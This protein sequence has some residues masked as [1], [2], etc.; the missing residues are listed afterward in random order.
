MVILCR[1]ELVY[2]LHVVVQL[3]FALFVVLDIHGALRGFCGMDQARTG[4][5]R[6]KNVSNL[7]VCTRYEFF[8]ETINKKKNIYKSVVVFS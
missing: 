6:Q 1:P 2:S 5:D 8:Q 3:C 4:H 7:H